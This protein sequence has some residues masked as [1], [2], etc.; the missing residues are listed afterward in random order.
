MPAL[1]YYI[2][3]FRLHAPKHLP[4]PLLRSTINTPKGYP[5]EF[6][7]ALGGSCLMQALYIET[8]ISRVTCLL[9]FQLSSGFPQA[10]GGRHDGQL[11]RVG[12]QDLQSLS[13][14]K[15]VPWLCSQDGWEVR[16]VH[17]L[18]NKSAVMYFDLFKDYHTDM[19]SNQW[20]FDFELSSYVC[21]IWQIWPK[22]HYH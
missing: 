9:L 11:H 18:W 2:A 12:I 21:T 4:L 8:I 10:G 19:M 16:P 6:S 14:W 3:W 17:I 15:E 22:Y 7:I 20:V 1:Q 5:R 13:D